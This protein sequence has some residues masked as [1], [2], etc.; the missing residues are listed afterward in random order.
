MNQTSQKQ[1]SKPQINSVTSESILKPSAELEKVVI[2]ENAALWS[3]DRKQYAKSNWW[4]KSAA[5]RIGEMITIRTANTLRKV[6]EG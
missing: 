2:C 4:K 3:F 5:A 6:V 1:L